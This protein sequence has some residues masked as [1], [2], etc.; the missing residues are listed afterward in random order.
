MNRPGT[1]ITHCSHKLGRHALDTISMGRAGVAAP[2]PHSS[3]F[4]HPFNKCLGTDIT[5]TRDLSYE[6]AAAAAG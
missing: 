4:D 1:S 3:Q 2:M 5:V 6:D